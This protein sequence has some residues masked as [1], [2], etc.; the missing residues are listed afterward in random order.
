MVHFDAVDVA[1]GDWV[2]LSDGLIRS[3]LPRRSALVRSAA[4]RTSAEQTLAANVDVVF[5]VSSLGPVL[6][7]R[8]LEPYLVTAWERGASPEIVLPSY[9]RFD[10]DALDARA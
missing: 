9:D 2:V 7:P 5:V 10:D 6:A 8:R 1:V 4:G 3:V